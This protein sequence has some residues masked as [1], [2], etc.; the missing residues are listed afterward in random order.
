MCRP[1]LL[2]YGSIDE[3]APDRLSA[4]L[5]ANPAHPVTV[6]F[7]SPGG[8]LRAGLLLGMVLRGVGLNSLVADQYTEELFEDGSFETAIVPVVTGAGCFSACAYAFMGGVSRKLEEGG[9]IG[10]H[11]FY[12]VD[13]TGEDFGESR[14][15]P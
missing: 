15:A 14:S 8:N 9:R 10:V 7:D 12:T 1:Q 2:A 11:Q 13:G 3:G 6:A 4:L 5:A